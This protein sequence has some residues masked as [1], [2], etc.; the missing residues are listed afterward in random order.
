MNRSGYQPQSIEYYKIETG[1]AYDIGEKADY[2][3]RTWIILE[4]HAE[5]CRGELRYTYLL[6]NRLLAAVPKSYNERFTGMS[7]P[8]TVI[9][10]EGERVRLHLEIDSE[11]SADKAYPY[12]WVPDT[13][14]VMY[15][16]PEE[17]STV[18][19]YFPGADEE[20]AVAVSC[21]HHNGET[22]SEM[23]DTQKRS[24]V[25]ADGKR[26]YMNPDETGFDIRAS[27]H[28]IMLKDDTGICFGS[29]TKISIKAAQGISMKA[30]TV[31]M[32]TPG[33]LSLMRGQMGKT[34]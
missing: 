16:M 33:E 5:L 24:L 3:G 25:T 11:Q 20:N 32:E 34:Y 30:D 29:G 13:G 7:I 21:V 22:C 18:S 4:K 14:S 23:E 9:K 27:K 10:T 2:A 19:L 6:G 8:G 31:I 12:L 26:M 28:Q 17:G 15:C 1:E